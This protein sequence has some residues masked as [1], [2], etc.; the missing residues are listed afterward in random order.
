M[1]AIFTIC[2]INYLS[3]AVSLYNTVN[4]KLKDYKFFIG[5]VDVIPENFPAKLLP[6]CTVIPV[7]KIEITD[8]D[9][10]S[11]RYNIVELN[12]AVKPYFFKYIFQNNPEIDFLIYLDPD[13]VIFDSFSD[14][15]SQS[16]NYDI[17]LTPHYVMPVLTEYSQQEKSR[18]KYGH[19]NGGF[20]GL[21]NSENARLFLTWWMIKLQRQCIE[22]ISDGYY[23]DQRW[24]DFIPANFNKVLIFKHLGYNVAYW[25]LHERIINKVEGRYFV[26]KSIP[27]LFFHYSS[28]KITNCDTEEFDYREK[29]KDILELLHSYAKTLITNNEF[30]YKKYKCFYSKANKKKQKP[31]AL[32]R[33]IKKIYAK[34]T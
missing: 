29:R 7:D 3:Q 4:I 15:E 34:L 12:T 9:A 32:K 26:N 18:I 33:Y 24:L 27:L 17:V 21:R 5:L 10:Q 30:Y 22:D 11:D 31:P 19:Y 23:V 6:N 1:K 2:S 8:L 16:K 20:L 13:I 14:L 25:N 28:F